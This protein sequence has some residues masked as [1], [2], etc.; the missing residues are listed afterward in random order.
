M[1]IVA[2]ERAQTG[3]RRGPRRGELH[4]AYRGMEELE[5][6]PR[7]GCRVGA[8]IEAQEDDRG[9]E[10]FDV[11]D[12]QRALALLL[13]TRDS[14]AP[15]AEASSQLPAEPTAF[16]RIFE[17]AEKSARRAEAFVHRLLKRFAASELA[18]VGVLERSAAL[19][20][21]APV[22]RPGKILAV[23][24]NYPAHAAEQGGARPEEP[25]LFLKASSAVIGSGDPIVLPKVS[26]EVDYEGELAVVIGRRA[27]DLA[28]D[29]ALSCVAGY[30][31][32]NDVSAR[33]W[34]GV[35]GQHFI[36][37][38]FDGFAPLGPW[39]VTRDAIADPQDL[40]LTTRV[41]GEVL[42]QARTKEM[43]FPVAELLAF[44]SRITVLEPGDV[45]LTGTPAGV[46]KAR[47]PPRWLR[48]GDVVEVEIEHV[49]TLSNPVL[50]NGAD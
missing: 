50:E 16:F 6:V 20:L 10:P 42:Q 23:A 41:S 3:G 49:G 18:R 11:I 21:R 36:G 48:A 5:P 37:K 9:G 47:K 30:T 33:D 13:A 40:L 29:D 45:F 26:R 15:D 43:S 46:G 31:A 8:W 19:R 39:L 1:R 35:R 14:G 4:E 28:A 7:A 32:A 25:V 17:A 24:R 12:L 44:A 27:K 38:S 22:P 2:F 34:Q